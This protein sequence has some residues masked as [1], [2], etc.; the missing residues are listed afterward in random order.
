MRTVLPGWLVAAAD[1]RLRTA[2]RAHRSTTRRWTTC[3]RSGALT[4]SFADLLLADCVVAAAS[5]ALREG[6]ATGHCPPCADTWSPGCCEKGR[7]NSF[8]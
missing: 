8:R 4:G 3:P 1:A 6:A 2:V 5:G 7:K